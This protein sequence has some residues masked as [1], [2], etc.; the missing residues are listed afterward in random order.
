MPRYTAIF[1]GGEG[2]GGSRCPNTGKVYF[3]FDVENQPTPPMLEKLVAKGAQ[4]CSDQL[5]NPDLIVVLEGHFNPP[6]FYADPVRQLRLEKAAKPV[7]I[8]EY[9]LERD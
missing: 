2:P 9:R 3:P 1:A 4:H 8:F 7:E 5:G 6:A